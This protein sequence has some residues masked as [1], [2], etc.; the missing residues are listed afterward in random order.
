[1]RT[2]RRSA[3]LVVVPEVEPIVAAHRLKYD[4]MAARGVPAHVTVLFPFRVPVDDAVIEEMATICA[5]LR[6]FTA[7]FAEVGRFP[8]EAVWLKPE[9]E[10]EFAQLLRTVH[11]SFPDC[12]PYGGQFADVIPHLT[13]GQGL[14]RDGAA[15]LTDVLRP[16]LPVVASVHELTLLVED[17][18]ETW[19]RA[20]SWPLGR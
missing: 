1:V 6:A 13:V 11:E 10:T 15:T 19:H 3:I 4:P 16:Q 20:R 7:S 18:D 12:P 8:G 17:D 14:D 9:P 5:R 2:V